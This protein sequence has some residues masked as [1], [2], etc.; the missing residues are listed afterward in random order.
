MGKMGIKNK[1]KSFAFLNMLGCVGWLEEIENRVLED[2]GEAYLLPLFPE[3]DCRKTCGWTHCNM[4]C[5]LQHRGSQYFSAIG[6]SHEK[7]SFDL[8][9][10]DRSIRKA[11]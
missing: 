2:E 6:L 10:H 1:K 11:V 9:V 7:A 5:S 8:C 4:R 3:L